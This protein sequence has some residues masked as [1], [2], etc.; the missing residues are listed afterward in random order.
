MFPNVLT[1]HV[2]PMLTSETCQLMMIS[3]DSFVLPF[4]D[5]GVRVYLLHMV[6][7]QPHHSICATSKLMGGFKTAETV[8]S[9]SRSRHFA[10]SVASGSAVDITHKGTI[11]VEQANAALKT[12]LGPRAELP[13]VSD[14]LSVDRLLTQEEFVKYMS[15][16][17]VS[18]MPNCTSGISS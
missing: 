11:T 17:L 10:V 1:G 8:C 13:N 2:H 6:W 5:Q 7:A 15:E 12:V 4:P 18:A 9:N 14:T 3:Q 16:A